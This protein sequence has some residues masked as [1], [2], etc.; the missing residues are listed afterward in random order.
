VSALRRPGLRFAA[1]AIVIVLTALVTGLLH[2]GALGIGGAVAIVWLVYVV[3]EYS[4]AHPRESKPEARATEVEPETAPSRPHADAVRVI[5][6]APVPEPVGEAAEPPPAPEPEPERVPATEPMS[7]SQAE[8]EPE[9]EPAAD[10]EPEPEP[11]VDTGPDAE[12]EPVADTEPE[13]EPVAEAE[14][15]PEPE[16]VEPQQWN[17]WE[18]ARVLR[19]QGDTDEERELLLIY[20]RDYANPDGLLP[21]DFDTLVRESF[22]DVVGTP[23]G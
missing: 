19:A 7:D 13:P 5:E 10:T 3:I 14:A 4:L 9:P 6:H 20:L 11:V 22:P 8:P 23:A 21:A 12:H 1:E 16:P 15:E 17:V 18:I 2:V